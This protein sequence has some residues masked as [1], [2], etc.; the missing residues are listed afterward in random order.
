MNFS[1]VTTLNAQRDY[2][3]QPALII[4]R[5]V[6]RS[7]IKANDTKFEFIATVTLNVII[8]QHVT[9]GLLVAIITR[10]FSESFHVFLGDRIESSS[11]LRNVGKYL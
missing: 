2:S 9:G 6:T 3:V 8:L 4:V 7:L 10:R 5:Y 1:A 11:F